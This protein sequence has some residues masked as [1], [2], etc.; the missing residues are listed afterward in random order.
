MPYMFYHAKLSWPKDN[1][2]HTGRTKCCS[3]AVKNI[4]HYIGAELPSRLKAT[5][6]DGNLY[7]ASSIDRSGTHDSFASLRNRQRWWKESVCNR[8]EIGT[9]WFCTRLLV[10]ICLRYWL[11]RTW[12]SHN[13][14]LLKQGAVQLIQILLIRYI[15]QKLEKPSQMNLDQN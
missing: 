11:V 12:T 1:R 9:S 13:V 2:G 8:T 5:N 4:V 14:D 15:Q 6:R 3:W 7:L 10:P